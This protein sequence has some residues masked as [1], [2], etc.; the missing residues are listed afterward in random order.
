MLVHLIL[1]Q[2][3]HDTMKFTMLAYLGRSSSGF[4]GISCRFFRIGRHQI[5]MGRRSL[6]LESHSYRLPRQQELVFLSHLQV[7]VH[8]RLNGLRRQFELRARVLFRWGS[9]LGL[10]QFQF[11]RCQFVLQ[12]YLRCPPVR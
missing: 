8:G 2:Q 5:Q 7:R 12:L 3:G 9:H 11:V 10:F 4:S 6:R 1:Q